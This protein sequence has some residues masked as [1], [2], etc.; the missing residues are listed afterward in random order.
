[1][2]SL[3]KTIIS[4]SVIAFMVTKWD[5]FVGLFDVQNAFQ[6]DSD[7]LI[8]LAGMIGYTIFI[9]FAFF[10]QRAQIKDLIQ[11]NKTKGMSLNVG[12]IVL[13]ILFLSYIVFNFTL[14]IALVNLMLYLIIV[15]VVDFIGD[16]MMISL[17]PH[18]S[19]PKT[20]I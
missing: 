7:L 20:I 19:H 15:S 10:I 14:Q 5:V 3:V 1:M 8:K 17:K 2:K 6:E 4:G 11:L 18:K 16:R 13:T 12:F 9:T